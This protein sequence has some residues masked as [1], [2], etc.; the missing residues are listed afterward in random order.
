MLVL[1][2]CFWV[3]S[4]AVGGN[5]TFF[6]LIYVYCSGYVVVLDYQKRMTPEEIDMKTGKIRSKNHRVYEFQ[7]EFPRPNIRR[8]N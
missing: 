6:A 7:I 4:I 1:S 8:G 5:E 3:A 2:L